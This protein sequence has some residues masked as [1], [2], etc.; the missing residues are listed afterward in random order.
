MPNDDQNNPPVAYWNADWN[1]T[2]KEFENITA[3]PNGDGRYNMF[4]VEVSLNRFVNRIPLL[5]YGF[6]MLQSADTAE[7]GQG[8][9]LKATAHTWGEDHAWKVACALTMHRQK[10]T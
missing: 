10:S 7:L 3:A 4:A 6:Q 1:S 2:T 5:H 9:R 8:M